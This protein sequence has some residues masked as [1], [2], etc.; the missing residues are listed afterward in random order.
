MLCADQFKMWHCLENLWE[1]EISRKL[2][3]N[4]TSQSARFKTHEMPTWGLFSVIPL[5]PQG[6]LRDFFPSYCRITIGASRCS[7]CVNFRPFALKESVPR[8][9]HCMW[10]GWGKLNFQEC[11]ISRHNYPMF[12]CDHLRYCFFNASF[13]VNHQ[14][15][16]RPTMT[17]QSEIIH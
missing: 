4:K 14:W 15:Q 1:S 11:I 8:Q 3:K 13:T 16:Q 17:V 5:P 7:F 12:S 9:F 6:M 10:F 2:E